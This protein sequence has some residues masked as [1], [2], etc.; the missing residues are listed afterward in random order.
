[1]PGNS[2]KS[3]ETH[4]DVNP[5]TDQDFIESDKGV[6]CKNAHIKSSI[7]SEMHVLSAMRD[8]QSEKIH[9]K[10]MHSSNISRLQIPTQ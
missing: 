3:Q 4:S 1:M 6:T 5:D 7:I 8:G 2:G 10:C 9:G